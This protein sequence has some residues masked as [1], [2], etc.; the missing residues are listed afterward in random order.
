MDNLYTMSTAETTVSETI[1]FRDG[2]EQWSTTTA[3]T[4]DSTRDITYI[5][6]VSLADF[7]ARPV[8][9]ATYNW[10]VN[11]VSPFFQTIDPWTLFLSNPRVS[12]RISNY[13]NFS[14]NL[15]VK[16]VVNGNSFFY[17]R[18]MADYFPLRSYDNYSDTTGLS[19]LTLTQA[20]QRMHIYIDPC[21]SQGG[22]MLLPFVWFADKV[23]L[24]TAEYANL[25]TL[26]I[27]Q[28]QGLKH[29]NGASGTINISMFMWMT[30]VKLSM[31]TSVDIP[32][33]SAQ[34]GTYDEYGSGPVSD[35]AFAAGRSAGML[36][37]I[38]IIGRYA[39]AT[40]MAMGAMGN[41]AKIFGYSRPPIICDYTEVRPSY[42]G[43]LAICSG[44]D[45]AVK[46]TVDPKQELSIDPSIVGIGR[47]DELSI[48]SIVTKES[49]LTAVPW[50]VAATSGT[51][52]FALR[53][54][55]AWQRAAPVYYLPAVTYASL[56]FKFWKGTMVYRFQIVASGYHKGRLLI[57]W[58]PIGHAGLPETNIQYSKIVD[59]ADERDFTFEVGYGS[60][61]GWLPV[62]A[63][64]A[65]PYQFTGPYTANATGFNGSIA[66]YVLNELTTPNST[67]NND[68]SI[69]VFM[70]GCKD[71][72]LAVP[73]STTIVSFTP[74]GNLIPQAGTFEEVSEDNKN[75]P[76]NPDAKETIAHCIPTD[77]ETDK[78]YFGESIVSFR[79]L[80]K[81]YSLW[82]SLYAAN[83]A[84]AGSLIMR[85]P[86]FPG[87]RGYTATGAVLKTANYYNPSNTTLINYLAYAFLGFRGGM[88]W[89][90]VLNGSNANDGCSQICRLPDNTPPT[91]GW[92][93]VAA[94]VTTTPLAYS[95]NRVNNQLPTGQAGAHLTIL[96]LNNSLE[97]EA[98][99][100]Q[101]WRFLSPRFLQT[102][103][104]YSAIV[105]T[106]QMTTQAPPNAIYNYD[107]YVAAAEDTT[108]IGFQGAPPL[109]GYAIA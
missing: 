36:S 31:P 106:L 29:A 9:L 75:A 49:Y 32:V 108:F 7:F 80:I 102:A 84:T 21:E 97:V 68:I 50:T 5:N 54:G 70:A 90:I 41:I 11:D 44:G 40:S 17:G 69:N 10:V 92:L 22:E 66:V 39:K 63:L 105:D 65:G 56:P 71:Y 24:G 25:G 82:S 98:P 4:Y 89:K 58:D 18:L 3:G 55:Q 77:D 86:S 2:S 16:F 88:R 85:F 79:T 72:R 76:Q 34:G 48:E 62:T 42:V 109:Q 87:P 61:T 95:V 47:D 12:N 103:T 101:R 67:A 43:R 60:N 27:R 96:K 26:Y 38:P 19:T 28:M 91:T 78:V 52:I 57:V 8:K 59:L 81:R 74:P 94:D 23:N 1:S 37:K 93:S 13:A 33:I 99:F 53:V 83:G 14:G 6:D 51:C 35:L 104:Q 20:S 30:D 46:L 15:H 73:T 100:Y 45:T 64:G 107:M